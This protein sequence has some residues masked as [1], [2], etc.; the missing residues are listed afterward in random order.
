MQRDYIGHFFSKSIYRYIDR[1]KI[2]ILIDRYRFLKKNNAGFVLGTQKLIQNDIQ[3]DYIEH[4]FSKSITNNR[5]I[6]RSISIFEKWK[7]CMFFIF[8]YI[9]NAP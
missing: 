1:S 2:D 8:D 6:D 3:H 5:Y 4:F 9:S 7:K